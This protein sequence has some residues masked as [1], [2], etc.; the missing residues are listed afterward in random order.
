MLRFNGSPLLTKLSADFPAWI[1]ESMNHIPNVYRP[2]VRLQYTF[3]KYKYYKILYS[4]VGDTPE[5]MS[6]RRRQDTWTKG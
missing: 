6:E 1:S 3:I 5:A 4:D 2:N